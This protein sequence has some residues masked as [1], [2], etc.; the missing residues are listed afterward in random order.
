MKAATQRSILAE[1]ALRF[2]DQREP[3][4]TVGLGHILAASSAS[5]DAMTELLGD[6]GVELPGGLTYK[7]EVVDRD[8]EGRPDVVGSL[9]DSRHLIIE[10]K[11]WATPT[12]SQP[13]GYLKSLAPG[14]CLL[15]VTPPPRL[16]TVA[17]E[18][19]RRC[20]DAG[21]S[22]SDRPAAIEARLTR[23]DDR[24]WMGVISWRTV[25]GRIRSKLSDAGET[26]LAADV[27]QLESLA[28]LEDADAFLPLSSSDLSNPT[29]L[30][31]YQYMALVD[32][33]INRGVASGLLN[34]QGYRRG[35]GIGQY[36]RYAGADGI[37][38]ALFVDLKRWSTVRHTPLWLEVAVEPGD[39]LRELENA[40]PPRVLFT[41][42]NGRPLFPLT[43]P[44]H[45]EEPAVI[46]ALHRQIEDILTRIRACR[47]PA[48]APSPIAA[49]APG[50]GYDFDPPPTG[51]R[52]DGA[53]EDSEGG[54]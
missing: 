21:L 17:D 20:Q 7:T 19:V 50:D 42:T 35:G 27:D 18:L 2:V 51:G 53:E 48:A 1:L 4:A 46:D 23:V 25:L 24:W 26:R 40:R 14:G 16:P 37:Q 11:F 22:V 8:E 47:P 31:V 54:V 49:T 9:G 41:G 13:V 44:L 29:P 6:R 5:R 39:A 15:V 12:D 10:G 45:V 52:A 43:L 32:S 38:V 3:L 33:L 30:R 34:T 28:R 36:L